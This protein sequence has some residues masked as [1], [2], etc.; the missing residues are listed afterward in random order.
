[1]SEKS[2]EHKPV[3]SKFNIRIVLEFWKQISLC[4]RNSHQF[5]VYG[6]SISIFYTNPPWRQL[7]FLQVP[8]LL[9]KV[10]SLSHVSLTEHTVPLFPKHLVV[11]ARKGALT[12][13]N[14]FLE[15]G[16]N[17]FG[18]GLEG[19][20]QNELSYSV[21]V[22]RL[23]PCTSPRSSSWRTQ[24]PPAIRPIASRL[25][26]RKSLAFIVIVNFFI[27]ALSLAEDQ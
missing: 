3:T 1:M 24:L 6:T 20:D 10:F 16:C 17:P 18:M 19:Y 2:L 11:P 9:L 12:R 4:G 8:N 14:Q 21:L 13:F 26:G 5:G 22:A 7:T 27:W 15:S 23:F 25:L